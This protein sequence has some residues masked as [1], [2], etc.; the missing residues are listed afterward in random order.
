MHIA[1]IQINMSLLICWNSLLR[2]IVIRNFIAI[3]FL[4]NLYSSKLLQ[5]THNKSIETII[6]ELQFRSF[7]KVR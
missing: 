5:C 2:Q 4:T 6:S 7:Q 1:R 3:P